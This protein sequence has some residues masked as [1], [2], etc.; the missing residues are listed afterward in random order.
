MFYMNQHFTDD[1]YLLFV[2]GDEESNPKILYSRYDEYSLYMGFER[3]RQI[4]I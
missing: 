1:D 3:N 4:F 2:F